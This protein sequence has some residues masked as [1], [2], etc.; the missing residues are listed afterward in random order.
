M[1]TKSNSQVN[2][3]PVFDSNGKNAGTLELNK[4]VF[5]GRVNK[6][7]LYQ[8][9]T[10]YRANQRRGTAS[11]K[12]RSEVRGGGKKPWRQKGTGRA[13]VS[14]IRNPIWRGGGIVFGPKPRD[15]RYSI[16][17]KMKRSA[18]VSSINAKL[19]SGRVVAIDGVPAE[20]GKTKIVADFFK[21]LNLRNTV[22]LVVKEIDQKLFRATRN[23]KR[24]TVAES[25]KVTALNVLSHDYVV[26]T[27]DAIDLLNKRGAA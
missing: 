8:S 11:T 23:I 26:V 18:F 22:L 25:D 2:K 1:K 5:S 14:S 17:K 21:K 13:R 20:E 7:L 6:S 4:D 10:M 24:M 15:F 19:K 16:P 3:I 9:L 27:K 12:T